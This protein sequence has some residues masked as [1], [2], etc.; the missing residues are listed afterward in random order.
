MKIDR[1]NE[2]GFTFVE[3]GIAAV[4]IGL[5]M[6]GILQ[7]YKMLESAKVVKAIKNVE[8]YRVATSS[9]YDVY[10][11]QPG[12]LP[13]AHEKIPG[14]PNH[15]DSYCNTIYLGNEA[16]NGAVGYVNWEIVRFQSYPLGEA[17]PEDNNTYLAEYAETILFWYELEQAGYLEG[18]V[19]DYG[20]KASSTE[21][22]EFGESLP[23]SPI[24]GGY[25]IG[26]SSGVG[27]T[28][29][30]WGRPESVGSFPQLGTI[31]VTVSKM[32]PVDY[33]S[34]QYE[35]ALIYKTSNIQPL[36]PYMA[37][38]M[39]RKLDD[40]LP[41]SGL[42]QAYGVEDVCYAGDAPYIY[43]EAADSYDCGLIISIYE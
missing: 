27:P 31:I 2:K 5:I 40:G 36:K 25:W 4:I 30:F 19:T 9:F 18:V 10:K 35:P 11:F 6:A 7:G 41:S 13:K 1:R 28:N 12:D 29:T 21:K 14:C 22:G 20:V 24:G 15:Y 39:D 8:A 34:S 17:Q 23:A 38:R 37:A 42:V 43:G 26:N 16:G 33:Y 32:Q 3:L